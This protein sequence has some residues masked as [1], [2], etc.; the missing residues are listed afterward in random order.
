MNTEER[1]DKEEPHCIKDVRYINRKTQRIFVQYRKICVN[2]KMHFQCD[3]GASFSSRGQ[4]AVK[5]YPG[6]ERLAWE[7]Q[8]V[9]PGCPW[10]TQ[11]SLGKLDLC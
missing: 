4:C 11:R 1:H 8:C 2:I 6:W 5:K 10:R 3:V 7:V 9:T